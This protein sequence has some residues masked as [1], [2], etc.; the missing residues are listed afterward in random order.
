MAISRVEEQGQHLKVSSIPMEASADRGMLGCVRDRLPGGSASRAGALFRAPPADPVSLCCPSSSRDMICPNASLVYAKPS[1]Y[2]AERLSAYDWLVAGA[3]VC[4]P[5]VQGAWQ[6]LLAAPV[7]APAPLPLSEPCSLLVPVGVV[8][9]G[10]TLA[11]ML[12]EM[13]GCELVAMLLSGVCTCTSRSSADAVLMQ[14]ISEGTVCNRRAPI[15]NA[16]P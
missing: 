5:A 10:V 8:D 7:V 13:G 11:T 6:R 3:S 9:C 1:E 12:A 15:T 2:E 4:S 16:Q 14:R